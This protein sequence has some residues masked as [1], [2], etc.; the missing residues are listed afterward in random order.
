MKLGKLAGRAF[1]D[2]FQKLMLQPKIPSKTSFKMRGLA[3]V[4]R[5]EVSKYTD[6]KEQYANDHAILD[7]HGKPKEE[8]QGT[9]KIV[10]IDMTKMPS[11]FKKVKELDAIEV[12]IPPLSLSELGKEEDLTL[13]P[14]D[15]YNLEFLTE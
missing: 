13:V 6:I 12:D 14:E 11:F 10:Q 5:E 8:I 15:Y 9:Q 7:E 2:S 3:K 1:T 4:I